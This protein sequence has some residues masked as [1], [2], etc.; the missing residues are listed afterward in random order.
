LI[1]LIKKAAFLISIDVGILLGEAGKDSVEAIESLLR[2]FETY[3]ISATWAVVG[4]LFTEYPPTMEYIVEKI[5]HGNVR[6]EI[7]YHSFTHI[8][9]SE[10]GR[11][12]VELEITEGL[13]LSNKLGINL[14]SFVFPNDAI[15][16]T[17]VLRDNGFIIYRGQVIKQGNA[18]QHLLSRV[19]YIGLNHLI[20]QPVDPKRHDGIW[21]VPASM[22]FE[23]SLFPFFIL[24][25]AKRGV[26]KAIRLQNVFHIWLHPQDLVTNPSLIK[27]LDSFLYFVAMKRD[28]GKI[29][30][31]T[32]GELGSM[33]NENLS[34]SDKIC[35]AK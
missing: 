9:F 18:K 16:H 19:V 10:R 4:C 28:K 30:A 35:E 1:R 6:H 29:Q 23:D 26:N 34:S 20:S 17:D 21:E 31:L 7:G 13:K 32:M 11:S 14:K 15:G 33:L 25:R 12:F 8:N 22:H 27:K 5:L 3:S 2:L 24:P